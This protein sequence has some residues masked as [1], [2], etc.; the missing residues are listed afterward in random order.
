M[1]NNKKEMKTLSDEE[2]DLFH[3]VCNGSVQLKHNLELYFKIIK[4]S[5]YINNVQTRGENDAALNKTNVLNK[6]MMPD[7]FTED[8]YIYKLWMQGPSKGFQICKPFY[9]SYPYQEETHEELV[10]VFGGN[11]PKD[12]LEPEIY[13]LVC[14][15]KKG[16]LQSIPFTCGSCGHENYVLKSDTIIDRDAL[17][18]FYDEFAN[19]FDK[20]GNLI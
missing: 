13:C 18:I 8:N 11:I 20:D 12:E 5:E 15:Y 2:R 9:P 14:G 10:N 3:K 17:R 1:E 7:P 6:T 16:R 19:K 4:A